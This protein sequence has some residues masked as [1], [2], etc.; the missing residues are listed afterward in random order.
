VLADLALEALDVIVEA[1]LT[2]DDVGLLVEAALHGAGRACTLEDHVAEHV[3]S[4]RLVR[5]LGDWCQPVPGFHVWR[6]TA[7]DEDDTLSPNL[8]QQ[9]GA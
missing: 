6:R 8:P 5:I 2:L 1:A 9:V 7:S 3:A 4:G